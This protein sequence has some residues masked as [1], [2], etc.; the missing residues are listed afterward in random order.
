MVGRTNSTT[1][2]EYA[3]FRFESD[4]TFI[5]SLGGEA[6]ATMAFEFAVP[7]GYHPLALYVK[8]VR[9]DLVDDEGVP[10]KPLATWSDP[11]ERDLAIKA[12][13]VRGMGGV[14]PIIDPNT[15]KPVQVQ[16]DTS[17]MAEPAVPNPSLG[18]AIQKGTEQGL[19][20]AQEG[21]QGSWA[22]RS[23]K[24]TFD[25]NRPAPPGL[26]GKLR[27]DKFSVDEST[28]IVKVEITPR[29]RPNDFNT[30]LE[31]ADKHQP[32]RL[33]DTNGTPYPAVGYIYKDSRVME[34]SYNKGSPIGGLGEEGMRQV[35]MTNPNRSL[36]LVFVVTS[37][38]DLQSFNIG[39]TVIESYPK[40][41]HVENVGKH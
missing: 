33:I 23:G 32:P 12:G 34:V 6:E 3:R 16:E 30:R 19:E 25:V 20:V 7:E 24:A 15:G 17:T 10:L 11:T 18:F 13:Q 38:V 9:V 4:S 27:I 21:R 22:I 1:Q 41:I 29:R 2:V 26:E 5:S 31:S 14:G 35:S 28:A 8:G 39:D 36:T 37:G 40:P